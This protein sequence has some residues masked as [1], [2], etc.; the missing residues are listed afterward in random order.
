MK[1]KRSGCRSTFTGSL[2][3]LDEKCNR[4]EGAKLAKKRMQFK[5]YLLFRKCLSLSRVALWAQVVEG[6][7]V[8]NFFIIIP[9]IASIVT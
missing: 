7:G 4:R 9:R 5:K 2:H 6:G 3:K 1:I 8:S